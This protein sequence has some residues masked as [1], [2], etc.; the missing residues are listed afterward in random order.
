MGRGRGAYRRWLCGF[1]AATALL[2]AAM[3]AARAVDVPVR[4]A[5]HKTF[6]RMV[7]DWPRQ[8]GYSAS[9]EG[10]TLVV[11]FD[12][13][14]NAALDR[15]VSALPDYLSGVRIG[16]DGKTVTF[17]LKR[18]VTLKSFR[19]GNAVALDLT[20]A[21]EAPAQTIKAEATKAETPAASPAAPAA[22]PARSAGRVTVSAGDTAE[23]SRLTFTWP[24]GANY[25]LRR[26]GASATLL[27]DR[28]GNADLA[29]VAKTTLRNIQNVEQFRQAN[30]ALAVTLAVPQDA[31]I[32]DSK[33]G[34]SVVIDV[35]NPG[36]RAGL[37]AA[38]TANAP[39]PPGATTTTVRPQPAPPASVPPAP[40]APAPGAAAT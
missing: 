2:A 27:F 15:T 26:D 39:P 28:N 24:E 22:A 10:G 14:I 7:F 35:L 20:P 11:R 13:P 4:A 8:T 37:P 16:G 12:E 21:A 40:A 31:E 29:P 32:K 3:P 25:T 36:T 18:P 38:E 5:T 1:V 9:V 34:R 23:Q 33:S 19:N 30:G 6:G 17:D